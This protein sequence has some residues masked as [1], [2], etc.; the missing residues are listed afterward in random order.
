MRIFSSL[1]LD[2]I[3]SFKKSIRW[4]FVLLMC[5]SV[6]LLADQNVMSPN[7]EEIEGEFQITDREI[8]LVG[9]AFTLVAAVVTLLW[10]YLSDKFSR[11]WLLVGAILVG[12]IPCFLTGFARNYSELLA[13]RVLTGIGIGGM[14]PV[15]FSLLGDLFTEKQRA[16]A[17]AWYQAVTAVG[18]LLGMVVAGF[19]GPALG[20]RIPFFVVSAPNFLFL[21]GLIFFSGEPKRGGGEQEIKD[22][23]LSGKEYKSHLKLK[24]Y[25][26]L[27][28]TPSNIW[29][30]LQGIPGTVAWGILPFY[31]IAFYQR[32]KGFSVEL[33]TILMLVLGIGVILGKLLGGIVGNKLYNRDKRL[34]PIFNGATTLLGI[35]PLFI[36]LSWP[37]PENPNFSSLIGP[38]AFGFLGAAI[39]SIAG[40]NVQAMLMNVNPPEYRGAISSI[41]NLTDSIGAGFGPFI[42]GLLSTARDLDFAMKTSTLFWIPCGILFF[43]LVKYLPLDAEKL[44]R[45]MSMVRVEMEA[46][47]SGEPG[48]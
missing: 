38:A 36:T 17:Q 34:L 12:E 37:A 40:P 8:G 18:T 22:L 24:D 44:R 39:L 4:T 28:K 2:E 7:I 42:G 35:I 25:L 14:V 1:G 6:I 21:L 27:V 19:L 43:V 48:I 23:V 20:W 15:T 33:G 11:K 16:T 13:L 32:H 10:G 29:L 9:S 3:Y 26:N 30:F 41:F 45:K 5:M 47:N 31:I 46:D